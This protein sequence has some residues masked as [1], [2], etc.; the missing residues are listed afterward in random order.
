MKYVIDVLGTK[1]PDRV[2]L[3]RDLL[4]SLLDQVEFGMKNFVDDGFLLD[5]LD[6]IHEELN[7]LIDKIEVGFGQMNFLDGYIKY[8]KKRRPKHDELIVDNTLAHSLLENFTHIRPYGYRFS[9]G[10]A[11]LDEEI[12]E[13][14]T[15]KDMYISICKTFLK[16]DENKFISFQKKTFMNGE[17][18]DYFSDNEGDLDHPYKLK[19]KVYICTKF[20]ANGFRDMLIKIIKE[21]NFDVGEFKVYFK[22]DYNPLHK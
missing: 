4:N 21:Y 17:S 1:Y 10:Q 6:S 12:I 5:Q 11:S 13:S 19:D 8:P 15:W 3:V 7:G 18:R 22:A 14:R 9:Y 20:D 16:L 2:L